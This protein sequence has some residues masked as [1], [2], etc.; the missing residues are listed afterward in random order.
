MRKAK[1]NVIEFLNC[2]EVGHEKYRS[3]ESA[4]MNAE[5][6]NTTDPLCLDGKRFFR[7]EIIR[8]TK[9]LHK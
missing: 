2:Q 9:K 4:F 5:Y 8:K 6:K 1:A 7:V 3:I